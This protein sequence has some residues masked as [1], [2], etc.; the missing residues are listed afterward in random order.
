MTEINDK[1]TI[2]E[3]FRKDPGLYVYQLGDLD[4]FF[5]KYTKWFAYIHDG[6]IRQIIIIYSGT[7]LPVLIAIADDNFQE[8]KTLIR[9]MIPLLPDKFYSHLSS[10]LEN[11]FDKFFSKY[12]HGKDYKMILTKDKFIP[13]E[14]CDEIRRLNKD[15][16]EEIKIFYDLNYPGHWFDERMLETGK[17]F[18]YVI[19]NELAGIAGIH[20]Y[21]AEYRIAALGNIVTGLKYRGKSIC[22]KVTSALCKDLFLTVDYIGLNVNSENTAA[23]KCYQ[24]LGFEINHEYSEILFTK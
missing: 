7:E 2:E 10:G 11:S 3:F 17:Y 12:L 4:D 5:F 21:S 13:A 8:T 23:I 14:S 18:G 16:Y 15:E 9:E 19:E 20:V 6:I 1:K 22:R 24:N